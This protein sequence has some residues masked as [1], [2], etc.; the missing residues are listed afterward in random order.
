MTEEP[1]EPKPFD[2]AAMIHAEIVASEERIIGSE[3]IRREERDRS[4]KIIRGM[5][6]LDWKAIGIIG[7]IILGFGGQMFWIGSWVAG[8]NSRQSQDEQVTA[9]LK[10][11]FDAESAALKLQYD[12]MS[13][14][15]VAG[16]QRLAAV[17]QVS[18]DI[19][20]E[21]SAINAKLDRIVEKQ[22]SQPMTPP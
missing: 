9:A 18:K 3:R 1:K 4:D 13:E 11:S 6:A 14:S 20:I 15:R 16:L 8:V 21:L 10:L 12:R 2:Y 22:H 7:S 5:W 19:A 17:E